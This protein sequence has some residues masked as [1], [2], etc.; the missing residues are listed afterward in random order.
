MMSSLFKLTLILILLIS[1]GCD[2]TKSTVQE[3]EDTKKT[4]QVADNKLIEAGYS[5]GTLEYLDRSPC[6]YVI[7]IEGSQDKLDPVNIGDAKFG[8]F[9]KNG[10]K[11]YFKYR[12][13]RRMNRCQEARP[14]ELT[15]I[16]SF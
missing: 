5:V 14:I 1:P 13:L 2:S 16:K 15:D 9:R 6:P 12:S 4:E 10:E 8:S 7:K 3:T 11:V